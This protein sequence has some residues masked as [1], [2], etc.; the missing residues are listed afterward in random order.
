MRFLQ[1]LFATFL[2]L[3]ASAAITQQTTSDGVFASPMMR[4]YALNFCKHENRDCG[5]PAADLFCQELGFD[6]AGAFTPDPRAGAR[7][8]VSLI[9]G[10][11]KLCEGTSCEAFAAITCM[12]TPVAPPPVVVEQESDPVPP[13]ATVP[14]TAAPET[15]SVPAQRKPVTDTAD[16]PFF[17]MDQNY[18]P[19]LL[20]SG[21]TLT[22]CLDRYCD[23]TSDAALFLG[24]DAISQTQ[25]FVWDA[26]AVR[27]ATAVILQISALPFPDF[28]ADDTALDFPGLVSA[29]VYPATGKLRLDFDDVYAEY[30]QIGR[31]PIPDSFY[32]RVIP[33][34]SPDDAALYAIPSNVMRVHYAS[35]GISPPDFE[36]NKE[37]LGGLDPLPL[38]DVR[39]VEYEIPYL[40]RSSRWGCVVV[41]DYKPDIL[42]QV[43]AQFPVGTEICPEIYRGEGSG[44]VE[45]L[46]EFFDWATESFDWLGDQYDA[47]LDL[48]ADLIVD[49]S[50]LGLQCKW[51]AEELGGD[52]SV[53]KAGAKIAV[54]TGAAALGL[55]PTIPSY[56][57]LID[58]GIDYAAELAVEQLEAQTGVPCFGPCADLVRDSIAYL[59]DE[60]KRQSVAPGCVDPTEAHAYGREPLCPWPDLIVKPARYATTTLPF[61]AVTVIRTAA[62]IPADYAHPDCDL[63]MGTTFDKHFDAQIWAGPNINFNTEMPEMDYQ[64]RL[65]D[66]GDD[67]LNDLRSA[68]AGTTKTFYYTP[69]PVRFEFPWMHQ[70]WLTSQQIRPDE[71]GPY[72][73]DWQNMYFESDMTFWATTQCAGDGADVTVPIGAWGG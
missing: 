36:L 7:G 51:L 32:I 27:D 15:A 40:A 20:Y 50:P 70:M 6:Q 68:P 48:A 13:V 61:M 42:D 67:S 60:L 66:V 57:E 58:K 72:G 28:R 8:V 18:F 33:L 3:S 21:A 62:E 55:P 22:A 9:F 26:S 65:Y 12:T 59:G 52:E 16:D 71:S 11:G 46:G 25:E 17:T 54:Q 56:N 34:Q 2:L 44:K 53:C 41:V 30:A 73:H 37:Y 35:D 5:K 10:D 69:T 24:P 63:F 1:I 31:G 4:G 64:A 38:F 23:I 47:L 19:R 29:N 14:E 49:Y 39:I 43:A 45:T